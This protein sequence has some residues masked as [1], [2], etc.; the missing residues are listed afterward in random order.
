M[1][2]SVC[3]HQLIVNKNKELY[4]KEINSTIIHN[5]TTIYN[6][7]IIIGI[8]IIVHGRKHFN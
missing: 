4:N 1:H 8:M 2:D 3:V 6:Y 5:F 7:R